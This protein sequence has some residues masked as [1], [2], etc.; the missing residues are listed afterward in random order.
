MIEISYIEEEAYVYVKTTSTFTIKDV[1][2]FL[3][4][5]MIS[6]KEHQCHRILLDHRKCKFE[7]EVIEIHSITKYLEK[8]GFNIKYKG[9]VVYD[10]DDEKYEF[11]DTVA[12]NWSNGVIR[13]FNDYD[14]AKA[15]LL[16]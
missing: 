1:D 7:A 16:K 8:Y 6:A 9:A 3:K 10:Q 4:D 12:Q 5:S 11:A 13:F 15:W 2:R 14:K